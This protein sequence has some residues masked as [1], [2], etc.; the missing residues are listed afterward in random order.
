M[1]WPVVNCNGLV[2]WLAGDNDYH[3]FHLCF[4]N[5]RLQ[6]VLSSLDHNGDDDYNGDDDDEVLNCSAGG[7]LQR[8]GCDGCHDDVDHN[9][10]GVDDSAF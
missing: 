9:D 2:D 1:F 6:L 4:L 3:H 5:K 10:D 8:I 7:E